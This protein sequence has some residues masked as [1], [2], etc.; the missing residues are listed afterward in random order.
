MKVVPRE[1][2]LAAAESIRFFVGL[3]VLLYGVSQLSPESEECHLDPILQYP[4]KEEEKTKKEGEGKHEPKSEG[5]KP[6][7][8]VVRLALQELASQQQTT[9]YV[10][11]FDIRTIINIVLT[12]LFSPIGC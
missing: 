8:E 1:L 10:C 7:D 2:A 11:S 9:R 4:Y 5:F 6:G 3:C 12:H